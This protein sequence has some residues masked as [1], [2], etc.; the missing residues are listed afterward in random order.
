MLAK[1]CLLITE[2]KKLDTYLGPNLLEG[3]IINL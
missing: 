1:S 2:V 3:V